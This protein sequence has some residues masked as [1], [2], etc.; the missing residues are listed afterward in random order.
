[1]STLRDK[2]N[3]FGFASDEDLGVFPQSDQSLHIL[4]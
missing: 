1:M 3:D 4:L 2:T